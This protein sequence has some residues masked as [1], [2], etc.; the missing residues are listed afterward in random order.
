[1]FK[2]GVNAQNDASESSYICD[3]ATEEKKKET[4]GS[5]IADLMKV[6]GIKNPSE[7][8]KHSGITSQQISRILKNESEMGMGTAKKIADALGTTVAYIVGEV[9]DPSPDAMNKSSYTEEEIEKL[10]FRSRSS[11][12]DLADAEDMERVHKALLREYEAAKRLREF[13]E[14]KY[15][16][17]R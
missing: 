8:A 1:M 3:M 17:K 2:T 5:R 4:V 11:E 13:E 12:G 15:N 14:R 7:L 6:R 9:N 10:G 16:N